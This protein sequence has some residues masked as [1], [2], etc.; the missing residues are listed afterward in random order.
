MSDKTAEQ[1]FADIRWSATEGKAVCTNCACGTCYE[2]R[3]PNGALRFLRKACRK[4]FSLTSGTLFAFHKLPLQTYLAAILIFCNEVKGK[5]ALALSRDLGVHYKTAFVLSHKLR[6]A[7]AAEMKGYKLGGVGKTVEVDGGYFGGYVKP[8]N[9]R[10]NRRDLRRFRNQSDKRQC[11]VVVRERDGHTLPSAFKSEV[12]ALSF[13]RNRV[14][15][16]TEVMADDAT[17]WNALHARKRSSGST[18]SSLIRWTVPAP[19][20]L[21]ASSAGCV[22]PSRAIT[23]T[24]REPTSLATPRRA[25][26]ARITD[27]TRTALRSGRVLFLRCAT[28]PAW[29]FA[30]T[31]SVLFESGLA[32]QRL[33]QG[34]AISQRG[35]HLHNGSSKPD[36]SD[37]LRS[38][39]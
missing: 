16:G 33:R 3:R 9:H 22:G 21:R 1:T 39:V 20:G 30:A 8:A 32:C 38:C 19:T 14:A 4:D 18:A 35:A 27:A 2:A 6:E 28:S 12:D 25:R 37:R 13:I 23:T 10:E 31:G 5:S 34:A 26:G 7:M 15:E 17:S 11:V 29:T 24:S 36:E